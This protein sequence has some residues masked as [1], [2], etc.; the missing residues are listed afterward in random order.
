MD[1]EKER[2][3]ERESSLGEPTGERNG[4]DSNSCLRRMSR[5]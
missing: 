2:E 4:E 3:R 1:K 5:R